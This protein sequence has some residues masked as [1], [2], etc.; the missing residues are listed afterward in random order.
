MSIKRFTK[1]PDAKLDYAGDWSAWLGTDTIATSSWTIP[2]G[3]TMDSETNTAT[4]VL[5]WLSGGTAGALYDLT[6]HITTA[7]G[8]EDDRTITISVEER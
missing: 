3:I 6:N 7:G 1:D 2:D 8:R 4:S 5:I